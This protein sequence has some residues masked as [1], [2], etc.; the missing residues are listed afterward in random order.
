MDLICHS[1]HKLC[2]KMHCA[3]LS[4]FLCADLH[5]AKMLVTHL[6]QLLTTLH[7]HVNLPINLFP[8]S[9]F[10]HASQSPQALKTESEAFKMRHRWCLLPKV[11]I[12][13]Q[14]LAVG[15]FSQ[16]C[17]CSSGLLL[18]G[19]LGRLCSQQSLASSWPWLNWACCC[20]SIDPFLLY[21]Q[22][23]CGRNVFMPGVKMVLEVHLLLCV[24]LNLT[25]LLNVPA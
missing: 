25:F 16:D 7:S 8:P 24:F 3:V 22:R 5:V 13:P 18:T 14:P 19:P 1:S 21:F 10:S 23:I 4:P 11:P 17:C 12:Y 2:I 20:R 6:S 15:Y 9:P